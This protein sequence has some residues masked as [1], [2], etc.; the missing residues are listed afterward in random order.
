MGVYV[1]AVGKWD[2][3]GTVSGQKAFI[4]PQAAWYP[5]P[6]CTLLCELP[7]SPWPAEFSYE[8]YVGA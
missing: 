8:C 2:E 1:A 5:R 3:W 7:L 6:P 4:S